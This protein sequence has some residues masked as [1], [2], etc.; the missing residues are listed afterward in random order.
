MKRAT[1][2]ELHMKTGAVVREAEEGRVV[3][4][5]R[6]GVPVAELRPLRPK[7]RSAGFTAEHWEFVRQ[8]PKVSDSGRWLEKNR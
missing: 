6:R 5:L 3:T 2:R 4:I 8:F 7:A 1:I